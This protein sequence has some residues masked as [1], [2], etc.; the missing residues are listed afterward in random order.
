MAS[1]Q[2]GTCPGNLL[3]G[4]VSSCMPTLTVQKPY[5]Y[6]LHIPGANSHIKKMR[7]C[8]KK[9]LWFLSGCLALKVHMGGWGETFLVTF[10]VLS[11]KT[12]DRR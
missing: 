1:L 10:W 8:A 9:Q 2:D 3:Q 6:G 12:Y 5:P 4:V 11:K 7:G